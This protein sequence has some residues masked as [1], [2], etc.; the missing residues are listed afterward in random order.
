MFIL[1]R[2][3][4]EKTWLTEEF[5]GFCIVAKQLMKRRTFKSQEDLWYCILTEEVNYQHCKEMLVFAV[6]FLSRT[7]DETILESFFAKVKDTDKDGRPLKHETC[8]KTCFL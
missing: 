3:D 7:F 2:S 4:Q 1:T 5:R 6:H 8:E